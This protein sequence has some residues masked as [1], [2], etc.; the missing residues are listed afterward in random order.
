M[1]RFEHRFSA[2]GGPARFVLDHE[3]ETVALAAIKA[4]E[5]E[6]RRLEQKYSR[7]SDASLTSAVNRAAG[8]AIPTPIDA[9][10]AGLLGYAE[11]LWQQS[12]GLFDVTAGILRRVWN[13]SS[14]E[15]PAQAQLD[16]LL[17]LIAWP[18]VV[19]DDESIV[20]PKKG[21]E[22]DFGGFVKEY[23]CDA[24]AGVLRCHGFEHALVDLAG[25][26]AA[27]GTQGGG[28][29]WQIGI[30]H[31]RE[32]ENAVALV[33]LPG[34][35]LASSGDY[36]RC[37]Q[38][39]EQRYG[40]ILNPTTGWPAQGLA[41]VTVIAEQCLVAGSAATIA[42]LKPRD[43]ALRW[44]ADLGVP[45]LAIDTDMVCHGTIHAS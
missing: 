15:I 37:I 2:M 23:A 24:V 13:F 3:D 22:I 7:F 34:G 30:R 10:T 26:L 1:Q 8:S 32:Q 25:D 27:L 12:N 6:V 17:P 41:A 5:A 29:A 39:G 18:S 40:H 11:T 14:G 19:W 38:I 9:E 16:A 36:E 31:P 21:M 28:E 35:G 42:M 44:L 4:A 20:L 43:D 33:S 45:W